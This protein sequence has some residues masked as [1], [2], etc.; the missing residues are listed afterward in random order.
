[1]QDNGLGTNVKESRMNKLED[2][3][4]LKMPFEMSIEQ[5]ID[6]LR[7]QIGDIVDH[8]D[9]EIYKIPG[10]EWKGPYIRGVLK[11]SNDE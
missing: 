3:I 1:M 10:K 7:R 9:W 6:E 8:Y 5:A 11:V 2:K 4:E